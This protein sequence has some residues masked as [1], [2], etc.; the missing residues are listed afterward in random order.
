MWN[1]A[2]RALVVLVVVLLSAGCQSVNVISG[3]EENQ[4]L[5]IIVLLRQNG[6]TA[7]KSPVEGGQDIAWTVA[8]DS[9][10]ASN[11]FLVLAENELPRDQ[12]KG[13]E[14][15]F[16]QS[17]L[18]PTETEEKAIFLQAQSGELARTI[19]RMPS[20]IDARVHISI[21][22]H[23]PLRQLMQG[24]KPPQP[25][26]SVFVKYWLPTEETPAESRLNE[27]DI[28]R[29]ISGSVEQLEVANV[30]VVMKAV[31]QD[32]SGLTARAGGPDPTML[33]YP[34]AGLTLLLVVI[35]V[36]MAL[37]NR[38]LSRQ[39]ATPALKK[40]ASR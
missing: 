11:A 7:T 1:R 28:K 23:D 33:F 30:D 9:R 27:S 37:R 15:F 12:P 29:L 21:P 34:L 8:V 25:S 6:I 26:A 36:V 13:F 40:V 20:V 22:N 24:E 35:V 16:G 14:A 17:K 5:E 10:D 4:A 18:I 32:M 19:E 3:L 39:M 2:A 31:Q 38:S